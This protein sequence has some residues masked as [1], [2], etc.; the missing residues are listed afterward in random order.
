MKFRKSIIQPFVVNNTINIPARS[1][2]TL[3]GNH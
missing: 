1:V 2:V 3:T